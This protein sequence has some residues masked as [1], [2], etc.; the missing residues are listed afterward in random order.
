MK[1]L[2]R[3]IPWGRVCGMMAAVVV[4]LLCVLSGIEPI[5]IVRRAALTFVVVAACTF[6]INTLL[7]AFEK[8]PTRSMR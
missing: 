7:Q 2:R 3:K 6:A 8:R 4:T 1:R 5:E